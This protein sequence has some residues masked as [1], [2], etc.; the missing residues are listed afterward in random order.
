MYIS[1][2]TPR[3]W[4]VW[5]W[6]FSTIRFCRYVGQCLYSKGILFQRVGVFYYNRVYKKNNGYITAVPRDS[7]TFLFDVPKGS[8]LSLHDAMIPRIKLLQSFTLLFMR[9]IRLLKE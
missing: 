2:Y 5:S 4:R 7:F 3:V 8:Y 9:M 1:H 6:D